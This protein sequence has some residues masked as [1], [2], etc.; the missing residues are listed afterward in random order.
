MLG[1]C[2][3]TPGCVAYNGISY[4]GQAQ[5][6]GLGEAQLANA[7]GQYSLPGAAT[8]SAAVQSFVSITPPNETISMI[9]GP[10]AAGYPI[11]NYEYAV[12]SIRQPSAAAAS[13]LRAFLH[14]VI[15]TGN[16]PSVRDPGGLPAAARRPDER[17]ASSR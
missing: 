7:A 10:A 17:W 8:I 9:D 2:K 11:V 12:V 6:A 3:S 13:Q 14:W 16:N 5:S 1:A 15:T 4:L